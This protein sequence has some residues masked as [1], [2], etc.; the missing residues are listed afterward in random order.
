M[1]N[2]F[3]QLKLKG[4]ALFLVNKVMAFTFGEQLN[5]DTAVIHVEKLIQMSMVHIQL[6]IKLL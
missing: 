2:N 4:G 3:E 1:L 6:S 5:E